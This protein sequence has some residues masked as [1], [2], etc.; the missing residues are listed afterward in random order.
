MSKSDVEER[1]VRVYVMGREYKVPFG[2]TIM[3]A[4]EY[5]GYRFIRGA[6]CRGGFCGACATVYRIEGDYKLRVAL[7]CQKTVEDGMYLTQLPFTPANKPVYDV[8]KLSPS[9]NVLLEYYPEIAKCVSCN[10]CTKACPQDL[11][12]MDYV[13]AALRGDFEEVARLSFDCITCGLC[14]MRCPTE[15]VPYSAA[16]LA[17]RLYGKYVMPR[18]KHVD[19]RI[20]EIEE[21]KFDGEIKNLMSASLDVLKEMYTK[22]E[23]EK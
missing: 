5:A 13:Q 18:A 7:A 16:L 10:T 9:V 19:K 21:G 11:E 22:R 12:V 17:R 2:L 1:K 20:K 4:M 14:A 8:E 23:I 15:I 6:G 3:K